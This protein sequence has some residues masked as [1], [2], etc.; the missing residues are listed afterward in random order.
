MTRPSTLR[1]EASVAL[2]LN[3]MVVSWTCLIQTKNIAAKGLAVP[4]SLFQD[5]TAQVAS[6]K[7]RLE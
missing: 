1:D 3:L 4:T 7:L 6:H 2:H 5:M